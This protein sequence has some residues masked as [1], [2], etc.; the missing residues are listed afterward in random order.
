MNLHKHKIE[1][2]KQFNIKNQF[3]MRKKL[4]YFYHSSFNFFH[5][6]NNKVNLFIY[7]TCYEKTLIK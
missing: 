1:L 3:L 4:F 6:D 5:Y 7:L 2:I